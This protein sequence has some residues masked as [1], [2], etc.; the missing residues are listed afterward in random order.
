MSEQN[1]QLEHVEAV[2]ASNETPDTVRAGMMDRFRGFMAKFNVSKIATAI[3]A[4]AML[5]CAPGDDPNSA[6]ASFDE[7]EETSNEIQPLPYNLRPTWPLNDTS[8]IV[9]HGNAETPVNVAIYTEKD[10]FNIIQTDIN[11][12]DVTVDISQLKVAPDSVV[13]IQPTD[14]TGE[15]FRGI[16]LDAS[17]AVFDGLEQI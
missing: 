13:Y 3:A 11:G 4:A 5:S 15:N 10:P 8:K 14:S 17:E 16:K 7:V 9:F 1:R 12:A 6:E 2:S